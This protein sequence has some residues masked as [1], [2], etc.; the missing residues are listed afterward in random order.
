VKRKLRIF[1][2]RKVA[3]WADA[4][5]ELALVAVNYPQSAYTA[6]QKSLQGM[7]VS[8]ES[9]EGYCDAFTDVEKAISSF[10]LFGDDFDEDDLASSSRSPLKHAGM[11][12][13]DPIASAKSNYEAST[14]VNVHLWLPLRVNF[15]SQI[16]RPSAVKSGPNSKSARRR[17]TTRVEINPLQSTRSPQDYFARQ[18]DRS[19]DLC[20]AIYGQRYRTLGSRIS[21]RFPSPLWEMS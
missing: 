1:G 11:A 10:L 19:M 8:P 5:E 2:S 21:R 6:L 14:L 12:L 18:G 16:I 20:Y 4:V 17:R 15:I 3:K 9:R 7:A 13:P